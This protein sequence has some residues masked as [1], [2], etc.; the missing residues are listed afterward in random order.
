MR[1][2]EVTAFVYPRLLVP[3]EQSGSRH[4]GVSVGSERRS[5]RR[6]GLAVDGQRRILPVLHAGDEPRTLPTGLGWRADRGGETSGMLTVNVLSVCMPLCSL[7]CFN[8]C[9]KK[10]LCINKVM[11][12]ME[13][14]N[15]N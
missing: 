15:I 6:G 11:Q 7:M 12:G 14:I 3:S 9:Q 8:Q 4:A 13:M 10:D 1:V 5:R 2:T